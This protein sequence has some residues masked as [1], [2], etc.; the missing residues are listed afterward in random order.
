MTTRASSSDT[1][2][3]HDHAK[4]DCGSQTITRAYPAGSGPNLILNR[5]FSRPFFSILPM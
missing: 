2:S 1:Y 5:L 4:S 3:L